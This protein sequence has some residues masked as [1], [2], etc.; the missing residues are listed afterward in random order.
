M[1]LPPMEALLVVLLMVMRM[2]GMADAFGAL[3]ALVLP[4]RRAAALERRKMA[5]PLE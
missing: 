5:E 4:D 3:G 1:S 2:I